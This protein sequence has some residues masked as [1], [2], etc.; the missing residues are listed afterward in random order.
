M[1]AQ[2]H[3]DAAMGYLIAEHAR[4]LLAAG[5]S[6]VTIDSRTRLLWHLHDHLEYG[7]AFAATTQI[8]AFL[9]SFA[10]R[11]RKRATIAN[12]TMHLKGF[13]RWA[14]L[15]GHLDGNPTLTMRQP[16]PPKPSPKPVTHAEL[17]A[18]L[19][20]AP[21]PWRTAFALAYY[22]GL[23]AMEIAACYR[24]YVTPDWLY[25]PNGKGGEPAAVPTHPY[26]WALIAPR[27]P[28]RL[29]PTATPKTISMG[30]IRE[31]RR[32]GLT[33]VHIHR[34]RHT[35]ATDLIEAGV[36]LRTVQECLRHASVATTQA[37]ISVT[38]ERKRAAVQLLATPAEL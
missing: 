8:E 30:A 37:Y 16:R 35:Y 19:T 17:E 15:A 31:F 14:D 2:R 13:Y 3:H 24:E 1:R 10:A 38:S 6:Q 27:P 4:H 9:A 34:L 22:E 25:V 36:D 12:Y 20:R 21:E 33:G 28:G 32:L 5:C 26:V 29:F 23:R 7:L 11:G 18:A